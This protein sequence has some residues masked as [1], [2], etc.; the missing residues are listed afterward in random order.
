M[1]EELPSSIKKKGGNEMYHHYNFMVGFDLWMLWF[2]ISFAIMAWLCWTQY[3]LN[4]SEAGVWVC[5]DLDDSVPPAME[6]VFTVI[7]G[8]LFSTESWR[9]II[10]FLDNHAS[11]E[12]SPVW[13]LILA[14]FVIA[15]AILIYCALMHMM[16]LKLTEFRRDL[17]ERRKQDAERAAERREW[18]KKH[19]EEELNPDNL[20]LDDALDDQTGEP[21]DA[22]PEKVTAWQMPG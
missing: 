22:N 5:Q 11:P 2:V 6:T 15:F 4:V 21:F 14:P 18:W 3:K 13:S 7:F 10:Q 12:D 1:A 17:L 9:G 8:I 20:Y 16:R 19:H